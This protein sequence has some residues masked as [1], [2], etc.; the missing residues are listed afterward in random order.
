[1]KRRGISRSLL[2]ISLFGCSIMIGCNGYNQ[3]RS[4]KDADFLIAKL[5]SNR[6]SDRLKATRWLAKKTQERDKVIPALTQVL[7]N[8]EF[9]ANR[10]AA[11]QS[12]GKL[13]PPAAAAIP[14]LIDAL[15]REDRGRPVG[16]TSSLTN[17]NLHAVVI[18]VLGE[19]GPAA[20]DAI[21]AL[22]EAFRCTEEYYWFEAGLAIYKI[23]SSMRDIVKNELIKR[24]Q[25]ETKRRQAAEALVELTE[26]G[27]VSLSPVFIQMLNTNVDESFHSIATQGLKA[28]GTPEALKAV[29]DFNKSQQ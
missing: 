6:S 1:M 13:E 16:S 28:I 15:Q 20:A 17:W 27:D 23:D 11:A 14:A 18:E 26:V 10:V 25:D 29:E 7:L 9:E 8:D 22:M 5:K 21:P 12:L 3:D 19:M 4:D 24:L 2:L